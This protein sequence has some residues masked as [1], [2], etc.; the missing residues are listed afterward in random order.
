[1]KS[2]CGTDCCS[3]CERQ[4]ECGGCISTGGRPFG[5]ACVAAEWVKQGG[6]L[7]L[8]KSRL[9]RECNSLGIPHLHIEDLHLLN[10]FYVN[11]EY[12]LPNGQSVKLLRD[13]HIYW[14]NQVEI[15]GSDRCYGL[16]ADDRYLL[17]CEYGCGGADPEIVLY[18]RRQDSA[19]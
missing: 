1:M 3:R 9:I 2:L 19:D 15:P 12:V 8:Q 13:D 6:D 4:A 5:G 17:V 18:R 10:G 7:S 16:A 14:G 11:L